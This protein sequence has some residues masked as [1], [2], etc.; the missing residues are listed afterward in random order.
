M[1]ITGVGCLLFGY[2]VERTL[3]WTS[4]FFGY[5]MVSVALTAVPTITMAYVSDCLLP[6]NADALMLVNGTKNI[7]TFGFLFGI[8]EW[9]EEVG[10]I[11]CFGAQTGIFVAVILLGMAVLIP[12][13]TAIR[14]KQAKWKIII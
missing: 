2:G 1:L 14:H 9:V 13:G 4:L 8:I 5:G 3:H 11:R 7:V 12:F 10:S 6:V